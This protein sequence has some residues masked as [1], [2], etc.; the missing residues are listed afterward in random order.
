MTDY[1]IVKCDFCG[2]DID[3][4][5]R[6][7]PYC[8]SLLK[9]FTETAAGTGGHPDSFSRMYG[10]GT[11]DQTF[12]VNENPDV[13]QR[14]AGQLSNGLKVL[15][16]V[17]CTVI[18]GIGQLAGIIISIIFMNMESDPDKRSFGYALMISSIILFF[19]TCIIWT[20]FSLAIYRSL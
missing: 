15:I 4:R 14:D 9:D 13:K 16:T 11:E 10:N 12:S 5:R 1:S 17:L 19:M 3:E 2:E 8:G 20:I 7:C 18:P 6:R